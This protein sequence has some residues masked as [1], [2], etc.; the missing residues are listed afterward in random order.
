MDENMSMGEY[1]YIHALA[2]NIYL[3]HSP[4]DGPEGEYGSGRGRSGRGG[5]VEFFDED[6]SFSRQSC[7]RRFHR[8]IRVLM[9]NQLDAMTEPAA[10]SRDQAAAEWY[11]ALAE[12][13]AVM[14]DDRYR[15]PWSDG[16][17]ESI[18]E[19]LAPYRHDFERTYCPLTNSIDVFSS[20][21][22]DWDHDHQRDDWRDEGSRRRG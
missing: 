22:D 13:L 11:T 5:R 8:T 6:D 17:P 10:G 19:S 21:E 14:K 15:M 12:E 18:V 2:Y 4:G 3:G 16:L 9:Q 1:V 20:S 7:I